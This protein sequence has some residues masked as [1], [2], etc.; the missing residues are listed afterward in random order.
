MFEELLELGVNEAEY[1]A[2]TIDI[3]SGDQFGSDFVELNPNSKI[4]VLEDRTGD[5]PI[6]VFES[7]HIVLHLADKFKKF[8]APPGSA[9]RVEQ[10]NWLF[11]LQGSAPL[12]GG[13]FGHFYNYAPTKLEYPINRYAQETKRQLDVLDQ[14]LA[15]AKFLGG[16]E[17]SIADIVTWPWYGILALGEIYSAGE[18]LQVDTYKNVVRWAKEIAERPAVKR[19][20]VV[21][22]AWGDVQLL[23]RHSKDDFE[24]LEKKGLSQ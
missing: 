23:E 15:K 4:P 10:L 18:F 9:E 14:R 11:W 24:K 21:N 3:G 6:R 1:D 5:K 17:Y 12:L 7:G 22:K 13:G 2:Y 20:R 19:G 8:V 16:D